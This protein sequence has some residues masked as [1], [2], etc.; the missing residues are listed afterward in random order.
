MHFK[1]LAEL[2]FA[3]PPT[4]SR[5]L[6]MVTSK[7]CSSQQ[8][9]MAFPRMHDSLHKTLLILLCIALFDLWLSAYALIMTC[10]PMGSLRPESLP[11]LN[12]ADLN[13]ASLVQKT[14]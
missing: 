7:L 8:R 9:G 1:A 4:A 14:T 2:Y 11:Q 10:L 12:R 3:L 5:M 13:S 6:A